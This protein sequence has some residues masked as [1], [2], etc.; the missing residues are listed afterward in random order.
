MSRR[1]YRLQRRCKSNISQGVFCATL[2]CLVATA[3][4]CPV[5]KE[6]AI[7]VLAC[8]ASASCPQPDGADT[9][10]EMPP[11]T[12]TLSPSN[13]C[14]NDEQCDD[15]LYCNGHEHC[16]RDADDGGVSDGVCRPADPPCSAN[17]CDEEF[18]RCDCHADLDHI[19][20]WFCGGSDDDADGDGVNGN[21]CRSA[22]ECDC[23]DKDSERFPGNQEVCDDQGRDEDCN[24]STFGQRDADGDGYIDARCFNL[25]ATGARIG[26]DDCQDDPDV[27]PKA[28]AIHPNQV[29]D[30]C[31][32]VDDDCNGLIDERPGE[33]WNY[34]GC[35]C[36]HGAQK[37]CGAEGVKVTGAAVCRS[38]TMRCDE[39]RH[40]GPCVDEVAP[41]PETCDGKLD[42]DCDGKVDEGFV[43][44][45]CYVDADGDS[46]A[47]PNANVVARVCPQ[48]TCPANTTPRPPGQRTADCSDDP[49]LDSAAA[50]RNPQGGPELCNGIDDDCNGLV[51]TDDPSLTSDLSCPGTAFECRGKA[52]WVIPSG[53]CPDGWLDC[54]GSVSTC[55]ERKLD[56]RNC[57]ACDHTCLFACGTKD[58]DEVSTVT[59]GLRHACAV[60]RE[61]VLVC[62]GANAA[63]QLGDGSTKS[64]EQPV[65]VPSLGVVKRAVAG[66]THT[67]AIAG[68]GQELY[69]WGAGGSGQLGAA[70]L[71]SSPNPLKVQ[72]VLD[73]TGYLT[74]VSDVALGE[75]HT[76]AVYGGG[77]VACWGE[78]S[79]GRL[80]NASDPAQA[81]A[82]ATAIPAYRAPQF[83]TITDA[84]Q[85]VSGSEHTCVLH[86]DHTVGCWG[87]DSLGQIAGGHADAAAETIVEGLTGVQRLCAGPFHTCAVT[88]GQIECWGNNSSGQLGRPT[89]RSEA[90]P[91][92]VMGVSDIVDCTAGAD[93]TCALTRSGSAKCWGTNA[94]GERGNQPAGPTPAALALPKLTSIAAGGGFGCALATDSQLWCWGVN[95]FGELGRGP[96]TITNSP[97]PMPSKVV[98]PDFLP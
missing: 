29:D 28:P 16:V 71:E 63:G 58:C 7:P 81:G 88:A 95:D 35:E 78:S 87:D 30:T 33:A 45:A 17:L 50:M 98:S 52:G 51:D 40:W 47:L 11:S 76:C 19:A 68:P 31:N 14:S 46:Y 94:Y 36:D 64:A 15:G 73:D 44:K 67:C 22:E 84:V 25:D 86:G 48:A 38:G 18:D 80:A 55:C 61:G 1:D 66:R 59:A 77:M 37:S 96:N 56:Y 53:G 4:A 65:R 85:I 26:G 20:A 3:E 32:G 54:D 49:G 2:A 82:V 41:T 92:V 42:E 74:G 23:D 39:R 93:Y 97:Q 75:L 83:E 90:S 34:S 12:S 6:A 5:E 57:H 69:C 89:S 8:D 21:H 79:L 24:P 27:E 13:G 72:N 70:T 10:V 91:A 62:W 43:L 9:G 60:T